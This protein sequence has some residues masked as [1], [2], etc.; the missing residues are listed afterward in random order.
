M[1]IY[2]KLINS[3]NS[4]NSKNNKNAKV[5]HNRN[6]SNRSKSKCQISNIKQSQISNRYLISYNIGGLTADKFTS[7]IYEMRTI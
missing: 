2:I 6:K 4:K 7:D 5:K 3:I 1:F